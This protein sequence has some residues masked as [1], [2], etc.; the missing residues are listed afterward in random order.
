MT[1]EEKAF[2]AAKSNIISRINTFTS[3]EKE[4]LIDTLTIVEIQE[5]QKAGEKLAKKMKEILQGAK[6][7]EYKAKLKAELE[8]LEKLN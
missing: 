8:E 7:Q 6:G 2:K 5:L 4:W 1:Q 3:E